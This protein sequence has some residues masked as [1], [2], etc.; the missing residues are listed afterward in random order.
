MFLTTA[1]TMTAAN[2]ASALGRRRRHVAARHDAARHA[3]RARRHPACLDRAADG[4]QRR[5]HPRVRRN[6]AVDLAGRCSRTRSSLSSR[7]DP[8]TKDPLDPAKAL[9]D[10]SGDQLEIG[11]WTFDLSPGGLAGAGRHA[12]DLHHE[13]LSGRDDQGAGRGHAAVVAARYVQHDAFTAAETQAYLQ[14]RHRRR[15]GVG[16]PDGGSKPDKTLAVLE[17]LP[18]RHRSEVQRHPRRQ[19]QH[20]ARSA[21]AGDPGRARRHEGPGHRRLPRPP[22]RRRDQ[23]H[24]SDAS[25]TP[26]LS[27]SATFALVDYEKRRPRQRWRSRSVSIDYAFEVSYLRALFTNS[28]LRSFACE[29]DLTINNL[30]KTGVNLDAGQ[31]V[32][33]TAGGDG[34][35]R[36]RHHR[37]LPG[38]RH[39]R[40]QHQVGTGRLFLRGAGQIRLQ[41]HRR[42]RQVQQQIPQA[43]HADETAILVRRGEAR[44][45]PRPTARRPR[46]ARISASGAASSF[47]KLQ[48]LDL[49]SIEKLAFSDLGIDVGFDLTIYDRATGN[50]AFDGQPVA[51]LR[52]RRPRLDLGSTAEAQRRQQPARSHPFQAQVV[53]VFA[54]RRRDD[55]EPELLFARLLARPQGKRHH[56]AGQVQLCADIR[57]RPRF[58]G[59]PGR[60]AVGVQVQLLIGW[61]STE[62]GITPAASPS[63]CSC[64]RSTASSRSRSRAC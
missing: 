38:P 21:A 15:E 40:R 62:D 5:R 50:A 4:H 7:V 59:R 11:D 31:N 58:R 47:N 28:E 60:L 14:T 27:Q 17:F 56:A 51:V 35:Q 53:P 64:R 33:A 39:Q 42:Q 8:A 23:Q 12:A 9:F 16:V 48:V 19:L 57:S 26:T 49:F 25:P 3:G 32:A 30:F 55:R 10:F 37:L 41:L 13:V 20:A 45:R 43:D 24:R 46:S 63:A 54:D 52:A 36:H 2:A 29:V 34:R 44:Q 61:L 18:D 1:A 22:R 6:G